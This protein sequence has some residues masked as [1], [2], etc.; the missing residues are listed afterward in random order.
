M[1]VNVYAT[2]RPIVGQKTVT[3]ELSPGMTVR[4]LVLQL[5]EQIPGLKAELLD[6]ALNFH[7]HMK[8]FVNG[9]EVVYL[10]DQFETVLQ[11]ADKIDIF[12]PVGGG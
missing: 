7:S 2:L 3:V 5:V 8:L 11:T 9:R 6:E 12:P 1:Q 4:Q 10:P